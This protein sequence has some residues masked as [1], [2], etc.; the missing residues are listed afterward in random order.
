MLWGIVLF[1]FA[2]VGGMVEN[3]KKFCSLVSM[4]DQFFFVFGFHPL[5]EPCDNVP[6]AG[7][8]PT[9]GLTS[10]NFVRPLF[11]KKNL[12][13]K[14]VLKDSSFSQPTQASF[15]GRLPWRGVGF[16]WVD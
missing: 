9:N 11:G 7:W 2:F 8:C 5:K 10:S 1:W 15:S 12:P 3:N 6:P 14:Y 4:W 16:L 13:L